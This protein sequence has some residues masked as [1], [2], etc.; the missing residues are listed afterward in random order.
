MGDKREEGVGE[1]REVYP[2]FRE[3]E[4]PEASWAVHK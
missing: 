4:G 1:L 2:G 3:A